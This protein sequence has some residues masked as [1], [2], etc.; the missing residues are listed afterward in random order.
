MRYS[1]QL[2]SVAFFLD[3]ILQRRFLGGAH[4]YEQVGGDKVPVPEGHRVFFIHT[5]VEPFPASVRVDRVHLRGE[6]LVEVFHTLI[7]PLRSEIQIRVCLHGRHAAPLPVRLV[8][9]KVL[10]KKQDLDD[11]H[12]VLRCLPGVLVP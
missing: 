1:S 3:M 8:E 10:D 9:G 2:L 5:I 6:R 4:R 11:S 12:H 7:R